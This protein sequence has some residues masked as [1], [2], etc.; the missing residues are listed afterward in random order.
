MT[1]IREDSMEEEILTTDEVEAR[2][3]I[4]KQTQ[5]IYREKHGLPFMK[6]AKRIY[7]F[8]DEVDKWFE[9]YANKA[10]A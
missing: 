2:Y 3:K 6:P 1:Y 7:Y 8:K 5:K 4:D 9:Q 10:K